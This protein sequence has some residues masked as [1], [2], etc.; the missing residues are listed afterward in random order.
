[1]CSPAP[2]EFTCQ[3]AVASSL[4]AFISRWDV[5]DHASMKRRMR[6][7]AHRIC[8]IPA[9]SAQRHKKH[10][11]A[12]DSNS[13]TLPPGRGRHAVFEDCWCLREAGLDATAHA[14]KCK[15]TD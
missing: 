13:G 1:M 12:F 2:F 8:G 15:P 11:G 3:G 7:S 6:L 4:A 10:G 9:H 5:C 14:G